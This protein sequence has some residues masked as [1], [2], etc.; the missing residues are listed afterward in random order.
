MSTA[1]VTKR[2]AKLGHPEVTLYRGEG[3]HYF[4]FDAVDTHN[5]YDNHS[6]YNMHFRSVPFERWV[7]D[8]VE[9]A[10]RV[11]AEHGL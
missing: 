7:Q 2:L 8:G 11:K 6:V 10:E 5:V 1:N 3:Y 4:V 9:F